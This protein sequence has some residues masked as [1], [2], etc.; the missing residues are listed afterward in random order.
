[1][2]EIVLKNADEVLLGRIDR[3]ARRRGW[4][5]STALMHLLEQGLHACE[6]NGEV[7]FES[8]EADVLQA[9]FEALSEVPDDPGFALI[10]RT[11]RG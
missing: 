11:A 6:G 1:M 10:G 9:A 4:D 8:S 2:T 3:I 7:R 5:M